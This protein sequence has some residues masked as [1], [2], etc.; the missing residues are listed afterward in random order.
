MTNPAPLLIGAAPN[1]AYKTRDEH[2]EL[3]ITASQIAAVA[4]GVV[5]AGAGMLHLHVRDEKGRHTLDA[6][7]YHAAIAAIRAAVGE[8]L[9]IQLTSEAANRYDADAQRQALR[10]MADLGGYEALSIAPRELIRDAADAPPAADLLRHLVARGLALQYILYSTADIASYQTW[11]AAG[12][13]PDVGHSVLLVL[14]RHGHQISTPDILHQMLAAL[15]AE[16]NP[17]NPPSPS[18]PP[19]P[20]NPS[21]PSNPPNPPNPPNPSNP[22]N[23][24]NPPT[25]PNWMV[26]AFGQHEFACLRE[27]ATLG[28]H[29]RIG[30]ENTLF[31]K[32]GQPAPDNPSLI[33][34]FTAHGNPA[35]RPIATAAQVRNILQSKTVIYPAM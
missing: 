34:Q 11:R 1:G 26:C 24:P 6:A 31:L 16:S 29:V 14:G 33:T 17:P 10:A 19:N 2:A 9:C 8:D 13:I 3:P 35:A 21:N 22:S 15:N 4:V 23:S 18:N 25:P 20:S 27:A 5:A 12:I 30:F 7:A 28:G 32:S